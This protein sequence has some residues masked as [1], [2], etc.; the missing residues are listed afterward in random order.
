M[1]E[2]KN[3]SY[4]YAGS[5]QDIFS[6]FSLSTEGNCIYGLLGK[7]GT[8]K[9]TLLYLICGMLRRNGGEIKIDGTDVGKGSPDMLREL[10]FVPEE[11]DLPAMS[12]DAYT[13]INEPFYPRFDRKVLNRCL[14][15]FELPP[16]LNLKEL[17]MG[18][19]K[20]VYMSF[21]LAANTRLLLMDEPT[22]GMD[23]PSKSQF[24][25]VVASNMNE[26]RTV[27]ISTHQVHDV[28]QLL[29]HIIMLDRSHV[30][31]DAPVQDLC[32]KYSFECRMP[33]EP[34]SDVIYAEPSLQGNSV[35]ALR[36]KEQERTML[37]LELLFN[38]ATKGALK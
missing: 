27:I 1:I 32:D 8:G 36:R 3:I 21:A 24:R 29:D 31:L 15:E 30:L 5:K 14:L 6:N 2:I 26:N 19:K 33:G 16:D 25:K 7:N 18:Q 37:N 11:F 10:F 35:I 12:L 23:I 20:K 28:E 34:D 22:N 9:S 17:S 13:K 4:R 38:A